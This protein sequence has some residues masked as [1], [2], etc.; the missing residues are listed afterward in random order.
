MLHVNYGQ[1]TEAK[2]LACFRRLVA[3]FGAKTFLVADAP[4]LGLIGGSSLTDRRMPVPAE[5]RPGET[6]T[7]YVP[8]R[9][10]NLL[11]I[12]TSWAEKIGAARIVIG[13]VEQDAPGYPD[14]R[15]AFYAVANRLIELGTRPDT[16][17]RVEAPLIALR[18]VDVVRLGRRLGAPFELTWS[19]YQGQTAPCRKC[20]SCRRRQEA[21]AEAG[22]A[23]PLLKAQAT[24]HPKRLRRKD[25]SSR[26][27][28]GRRRRTRR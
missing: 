26:A 5:E 13:A 11:A 6:P 17:I 3:H 2:E 8:F 4:H 16:R 25:R 20:A 21:F 10:A 7:T 22:L 24:P 14:C 12:A 18:K 23:D 27:A 19:C 28:Q 15:P 9:N 1:R